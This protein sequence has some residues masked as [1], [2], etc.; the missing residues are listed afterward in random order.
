MPNAKLT[1]ESVLRYGHIAATIRQGMA[2]RGW[3]A[4]ELSRQIGANST[5]IAHPWIN[6]RG[7]PG[8][9]YRQKLMKLLDV[10][11]DALTAKELPEGTDVPAP[12]TRGVGA[13][14][15]S[16]NRVLNFTLNADGTAQISLDLQTNKQKALEILRLLLDAG[17]EPEGGTEDE[18]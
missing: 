12:I 8:P 11:A 1:P 17:I 3:S 4:S 2:K 15:Q 18:A 13:R 6:G 9:E 5:S 14:P 7:A 16:R 10:D